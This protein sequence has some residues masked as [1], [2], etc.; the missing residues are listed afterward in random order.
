MQST[1]AVLYSHLWPFWLCHIF[2]H[3]LINSM[4]FFKYVLNIKCVF[5]FSLL[6][7][8]ETFLILR[9]IW[10]DIINI[11]TSHVKYPLFLLDYFNEA[12]IFWQIFEKYSKY[13]I[14]WKSVKW[15]QVVPCRQMDRHD[16]FTICFSQFSFFLFYWHYNP[17]WVLAFSVIFFYP[18][19]S[20]I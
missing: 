6:L 7:L 19:L 12:W 5:W 14:S 17:L 10:Q 1:Q 20:L 11:H 4:I 15:S 2:T 18:A 3:Y 9:R 16:E 8:S 13:E